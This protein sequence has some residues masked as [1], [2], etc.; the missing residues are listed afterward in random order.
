MVASP[1]YGCTCSFFTSDNFSFVGFYQK[2]LIHFQNGHIMGLHFDVEVT[3]KRA[4]TE[5]E[6]AHGH[7]H[8]EGGHQH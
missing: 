6:K 4:A 3:E 2:H 1:L 8:G 7:A 5:E